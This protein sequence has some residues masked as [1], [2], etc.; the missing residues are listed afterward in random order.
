M[1]F[2]VNKTKGHVTLGDIGIT[3]GPRQAVD[4]DKIMKRSKSEDSM[5]LQ[6]AKA[7]GDVEVRVKDTPKVKAKAIPDTI[8]QSFP[9]ELGN[10][11]KEII[12]EMKD[13]MKELLK[14]QGGGVSKADLQE[15]INAMPKVSETV[16]YRHDQENIAQ[17]EDEEVEM[18]SEVMAKINVRTVDNIVKDTEVKAVH[19]K[20]KQAENTILDNIDELE[21]LLG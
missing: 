1:F 6:A 3:L 2:I 8:G 18:D 21:D 17:R 14:G 10:I 13:T 5:A 20:E 15:L 11:K 16:I 12:G 7:R 19:Y 4:L 9:D